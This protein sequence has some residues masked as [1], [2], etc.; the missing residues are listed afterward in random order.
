MPMPLRKIRVNSNTDIQNV[1]H[2]PEGVSVMV[3]ARN[4]EDQLFNTVCNIIEGAQHAHFQS[5]EILIFDDGST[6]R[7]TSIARELAEKVP[8]V[9][10][11]R[12]E[13]SLGP[14]ALFIRAIDE[15][16]FSK[17]TTFAGDNNAHA[18]LAEALF[19]NWDKA[20]VIVSYFLNVEHRS[21]LR[22]LLSTLYTAIYNTIFGL[23][24]KYINGNSMYPISL[25][26]KLNLKGDSYGIFAEVLVKALRSG[27][28]FYEVAGYA[29]PDGKKSQA[30]T[31]MNLSRVVRSFLR[32]L[33]VIYVSERDKYKYEAKRAQVPAYKDHKS[34]PGGA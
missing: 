7:T 8:M 21:G 31:L 4:E 30:L 3:A 27:T 1:D 23:H 28:L 14:G 29:N 19:R 16:R 25:L 34:I 18:Y 6:D 26:K 11:F 13:R 9:R 32:L 15:A 2:L 24:L 10:V 17:L 22:I 12:N 20:D 5:Y 33:W